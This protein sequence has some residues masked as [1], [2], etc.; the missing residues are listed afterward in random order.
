M[1][2]VRCYL[3]DHEFVD[4][5]E[6]WLMFEERLREDG[7]VE[8]SLA[9]LLGS[10]LQKDLDETSAHSTLLCDSCNADVLEYESLEKRYAQLKERILTSYKENMTINNINSIANILKNGGTVSN[11]IE[12]GF[13][14][15]LMEQPSTEM[16]G[17]CDADLIEE[18]QEDDF[19]DVETTENM[20]PSE[21]LSQK[22]ISENFDFAAFNEHVAQNSLPGGVLNLSD[23]L[24]NITVDNAM[25][26][27]NIP[28]DGRDI[29][30][31]DVGAKGVLENSLN[32]K[33]NSENI[34]NDNQPFK[35]DEVPITDADLNFIISSN[36]FNDN[37]KKDF[38]TDMLL[39]NVNEEKS[40]SET[41]HPKPVCKQE[42][43]ECI[44]LIC[45][46][47]PKYTMDSLKEHFQTFHNS[48]IH[49]CEQCH[50]GF[51]RR[52]DL[53]SHMETGHTLECDVCQRTFSTQRLLRFHKRMHYNNNKPYE[54]SVCQKKYSSKGMLE[55]HMNTHTGYRPY[56]CPECSKDFASKYTLQIHLKIHKDRPR[57][58]HCDQ[59]GKRFLN[60][61]NLTQHKRS[62]V[63]GKAFECEVCNK[64]FT[65][66]HSLQVHKIVHTGQRP[67]ICRICGKSFARRPEIKD[68][69][70]THTGEKPYQCDLCPL[71]FAQRSN[72]TSHKK[73]THFNEKSHKCDQCLRSFKR[74]R[75]L[76]Y[77]IQAAHT[78]ERPHKCDICGAGF[79]YPEHCKKHMLIHSG[80]KPYACEVCGK[81]FSSRDNRN[82]HRFVHSDKK[83]YECMEC[84][85]GFMRKPQLL[86]HMK[87][88]KHTNDTIIVNQPQ[89][90]QQITMDEQGGCIGSDFLDDE[91]DIDD[92]LRTDESDESLQKIIF[93]PDDLLT[94]DPSVSSMEDNPAD[95]AI[96]VESHLIK[97][98]L[99]VVKYLQFE[100]LERDGNQTLTW[101]DIG[102]DN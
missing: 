80:Q 29:I 25:D 86:A 9:A 45:E 61:Q 17:I 26:V 37:N 57:P 32:D 79:V 67:F 97:D 100:D 78:G 81:Q 27:Q 40:S 101:V 74:K 3:C 48:K 34:Q 59:C 2:S 30:I 64:S 65:T 1:E 49:M 58:F 5:E 47:S 84:G 41:K 6:P 23:G 16:A 53:K 72:L 73:S 93:K 13:V 18:V 43:Q 51:R 96:T 35:N 75:L 50:E 54:C 69:E 31:Y 46:I 28:L 89:F 62:H 77:H 90:T 55:E 24:V 19:P 15:D 39:E 99:G 44:C 52:Q 76:E 82:A 38:N 14:G 95:D 71:A 87:Q 8:C 66:Q 70:R 20:I 98:E 12:V 92:N 22:V 94:G 102:G 33:N 63:P 21:E 56:K 85:A 60:Q 36:V 88:A 4:G 68:H 7:Q 91:N 10:I 83:P 42:G 11:P